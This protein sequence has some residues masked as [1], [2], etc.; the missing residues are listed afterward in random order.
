MAG[1]NKQQN[2]RV[3]QAAIDKPQTQRAQTA[4][5]RVRRLASERVASLRATFLRHLPFR[6]YAAFILL[7]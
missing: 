3:N 4:A 1:K 2:N 5:R 7:L 6:F